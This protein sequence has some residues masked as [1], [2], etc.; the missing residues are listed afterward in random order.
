MI[1]KRIP[2]PKNN[3]SKVSQN[4]KGIARN[5]EN[6]NNPT[7][8]WINCFLVK[9]KGSPVKESENS[10]SKYRF[11]LHFLVSKGIFCDQFGCQ[12]I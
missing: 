3:R 8:K 1:N 9:L 10:V 11:L 12:R 2:S 4:A 5:S 7:I 6:K